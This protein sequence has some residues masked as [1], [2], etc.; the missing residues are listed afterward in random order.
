MLFLDDGAIVTSGGTGAALDACLHL[1]RRRWG[2]EASNAIA[3][4]MTLPPH[5]YGSEPQI[6]GRRLP[7]GETP[8]DEVTRIMSHAIMNIADPVASTTWPDVP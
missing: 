5:R 1:V 6:L 3:Q 7:T 8:G 2:A 4:R